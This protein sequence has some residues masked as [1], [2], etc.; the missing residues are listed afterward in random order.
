MTEAQ[1]DAAASVFGGSLVQSRGLCLRFRFIVY[2]DYGSQHIV[3]Y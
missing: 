2:T 3:K 1:R